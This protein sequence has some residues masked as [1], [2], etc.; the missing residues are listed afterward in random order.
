MKRYAMMR[1][2]IVSAA[3][4]TFIGSEKSLS[5]QS[6]DI[7]IPGMAYGDSGAGARIAQR[8]LSIFGKFL[9]RRGRIDPAGKEESKSKP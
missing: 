1:I 4:V 5:I 3:K 2:H 7:C 9:L 6:Q 8:L